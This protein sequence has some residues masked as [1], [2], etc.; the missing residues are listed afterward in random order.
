MYTEVG[1]E[2]NNSPFLKKEKRKKIGIP[3]L[4][5]HTEYRRESRLGNP[6]MTLFNCTY[7]IT[8]LLPRN[9]ILCIGL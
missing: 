2:K 1:E 8:D 4:F 6:A 3:V 9:K 7:L 5:S